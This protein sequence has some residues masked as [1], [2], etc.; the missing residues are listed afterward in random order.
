ML[1]CLKGDDM[2]KEKIKVYGMT[3]SAC[4]A[5][6]EK[7]VAKVKGV[8]SVSVNLMAES[9][10]V[11]YNEAECGINDIKKAVKNAGYSTEKAKKE[12]KKSAEGLGG[13]IW[14]F[15]F[16]AILM[17]LTMGDMIGLPRPG[18]FVGS[19][20]EIIFAF[21]Q[22]LLILPVLY[23]NRRYYINGFSRAFA[24]APNM[25]T[26]IAVGSASAA[27]YGIFAIYMIAD[28][29]C[30]GN[31][32]QVSEYAGNL[33]FESS[34]MILALISLGKHMEA[35]SKRKTSDAV[36]KLTELS[37]KTA[38]VVR[39]GE[40]VQ[41]PAEGVAVGDTVIVKAGEGVPVDGVII[42]GYGVLDEAA[43]TGESIPV[44]RNAGERV[45]GAS[46]N[47]SGYFKMHAEKVGKDTVLSKIIELVEDASA[48]K[49]PIA[50][51]ADKVSGI[52]VPTVILIALVT[53]GVWFF[54]SGSFTTALGKGISVLVISCPCALGLA[55]PTAIMVGTGKAAQLGILI[56]SA[57]IL[58]ITHKAN[59]VVF[60]KTGTL[61]HGKPTVTDIDTDLPHDEFIKIAASIEALS[62][63]PL[64]EP[65]AELTDDRLEITE[66]AQLAGRGLS[67]KKGGEQILAG[68]LRLMEENGV[69]VPDSEDYR[70]A[71][72]TVLYF[73]KGGK[74]IGTIALMDTIKE[75]AREVVEMLRR[76]NIKTVM[77]TGD[78]RVTAEAV[79]KEA[80]IDEMYA[81]VMPQDKEEKIREIKQNGDTV[82]MVG[83]GINDAPALARADI[84]MAIGTGTDIAIES[85]DIVLMKNSVTDVVN[86]VALSKK[87]MLNI[88][89][90]LFWA[91][92]Y[93]VIGIPIAA[94]VFVGAGL[95]LT[96][97]F[98]AL[99][100]SLSSVFVVSNALRLRFFK[101]RGH[102]EEIKEEKKMTKTI[103]IEG[104][105][106]T[107]CTGRVNDVLNAI[108][109]VSAT[110]S[111]EEK[112]AV[113]T[114]EKNVDDEIL[115]KAIT[116]AGYKVISIE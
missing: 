54:T 78:N 39:N 62:E 102:A 41:I 73:A 28:G 81:E 38:L 61:T 27:I 47:K 114:L 108:D 109:G 92:F 58:E 64:A 105:M 33:Y 25:D 113:V 84:G 2:V 46:I 51:L 9:M 13:L 22:F 45:T 31:A 18:F 57:E 12:E 79:R 55:T 71:G 63:H 26:L 69:N 90:N 116:D 94:G 82:I 19:G 66:F 59:T 10:S 103:K 48:S 97:S 87:V 101:S 104:M 7:S 65:I 111:L 110:V 60:D 37:P 77:I 42:E 80:G 21:T 32:A 6:V 53:F 72:K 34:A 30:D 88:K 52:F 29:M 91:F 40:E 86:A 14:S 115:K 93:N 67:G 1:A 17:Y 4:S 56:K 15:V 98:A 11:E 89:E 43:I 44:E 75:D 83:D 68:N 16:L 76:M 35:R 36:N 8:E 49:A 112:Q 24:G 5:H 96:P 3:C 106:C 23:I 50:K 99:A 74:A 95:E 100:M 70:R 85:A 20:R 107:H